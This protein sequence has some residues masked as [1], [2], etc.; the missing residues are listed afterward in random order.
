MQTDRHRRHSAYAGT[1]EDWRR[2]LSCWHREIRDSPALGSAGGQR[3]SLIKRDV[4]VES[5]ALSAD[6]IRD[7]VRTHER[8]LG[9]ALPRS[10]VDFVVA[11]YPTYHADPSRSHVI[12][13]RELL[14][15]SEVDRIEK[16]WKNWTVPGARGVDASDR[17]YF[18]YGT[19]QDY[20]YSRPRYIDTSITLGMHDTGSSFML[21][22]H[23]EV[24]TSDGEMEAE[25]F[26][27]AGSERTP[28]F[29]EMM[30]K[31]YFG[32]ARL[33]PDSPAISQEMMRGTC[34]DL[35]PMKDVWWK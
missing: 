10:Y 27:H 7:E 3:E 2:F 32:E 16:V 19:E 29:A 35:L 34:A 1:V 14:H 6:A 21:V 8:R 30:R 20:I 25:A 4:L 9:V 24:L 13:G 31:I 18:V 23:P 11:Y 12:D 22:L 5:P 15:V 26:F 17:E 28:S 33:P